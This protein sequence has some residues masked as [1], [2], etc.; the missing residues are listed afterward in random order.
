MG[1]EPDGKAWVGF[2]RAE[3]RVGVPGVGNSMNKGI[4]VGKTLNL[5][6]P[7]IGP[8]EGRN[9]GLPGWWVAGYLA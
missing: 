4:E 8:E 9:L 3:S 2:T 1:L 5:T 7:I 6:F